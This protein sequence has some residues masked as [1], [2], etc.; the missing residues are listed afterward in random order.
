MD[1]INSLVFI[2]SNELKFNV[3]QK[4]LKG[5]GILL[6]RKTLNLPEIQ[7]SQPGGGNSR[8]VGNL[9][10]SAIAQAGSGDGFRLFH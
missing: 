7:S 5:S 1:Q 4:V 10:K 6:E 2:T 3:A 8:M 9:G